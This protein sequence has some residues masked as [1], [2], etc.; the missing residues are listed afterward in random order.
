[1]DARGCF[2]VSKTAT[3]T[4]AAGASRLLHV[5]EPFDTVA[6]EN[7]V[8]QAVKQELDPATEERKAAEGNRKA[9]EIMAR[10]VRRRHANA[11]KYP[12]LLSNARNLI[13]AKLYDPAEKMLRQ[14]V[15]EVP[16]TDAAEKAQQELD[17]IPRH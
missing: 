7:I 11:L 8:R 2:I 6:A 12:A 16:G 17:A 4:T 5:I 3:Y 10:M 1:V 13:A 15:T 9:A 14:I